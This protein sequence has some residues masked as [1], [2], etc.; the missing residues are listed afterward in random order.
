MM[1]A[2]DI[3]SG[4]Q[5]EVILRPVSPVERPGMSNQRPYQAMIGVTN[6]AG[7]AVAEVRSSPDGRFEIILAPGTYVLHPKSGA[8]YPQARDQTVL[9]TRDRITPVRI[10]YDS[11]IR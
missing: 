4:I 8:M 9:V 7:Q 3:H 1:Q 2:H 11:G 5:G 10:V 6:E